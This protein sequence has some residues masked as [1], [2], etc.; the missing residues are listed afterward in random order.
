MMRT[1]LDRDMTSIEHRLSTSVDS[2]AYDVRTRT[3]TVTM[4]PECCT[5]M[6]GAVALFRGI[7]PHVRRIVTIAGGQHD[8]TYVKRGRAWDAVPK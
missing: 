4:P 8:T 6:A 5:D 2:L 7:D 1:E 3:G